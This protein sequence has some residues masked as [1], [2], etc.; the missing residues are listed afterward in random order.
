MVHNMAPAY[1]NAKYDIVW[2]STSRI[3]GKFTEPVYATRVL[4]LSITVGSLLSVN[5]QHGQFSQTIH[6]LVCLMEVTYSSP[7]DL[8]PS[9]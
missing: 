6:S 5:T 8:R 7:C 9:I 2:V 4:L 3:L 1:E